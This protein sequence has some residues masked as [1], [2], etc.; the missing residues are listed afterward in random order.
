[1]P[2]F[3]DP[4]GALYALDDPADAPRY[5]PPGCVQIT[6][7][8]AVS[9]RTA[10]PSRPAPARQAA[11]DRVAVGR[12]AADVAPITVAQGTFPTDADGRD[13]LLL[14][15]VLSRELADAGVPSAVRLTDVDE[16]VVVLTRAEVVA[17]FR[18]VAERDQANRVRL[19]D[20]RQQIKTATD[21]AAI[22][23]IVW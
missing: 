3:K 23:A 8:E 9:I 20:L 14:A 2:I 11:R 22:N 15:V 19:R 10:P 1:M 21:V 12:A 4:S 6:D 18:A 16:A 7:A 5:L 17:L 13:A